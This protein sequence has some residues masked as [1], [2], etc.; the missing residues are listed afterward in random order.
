MT[1]LNISTKRRKIN[2]PPPRL[3]NIA[4]ILSKSGRLY[5]KWGALYA[6]GI[7]PVNLIITHD[8]DDIPS[9]SQLHLN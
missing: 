5:L 1:S 2:Q 6:K 7:V 4:F 3:K 8:S 9:N